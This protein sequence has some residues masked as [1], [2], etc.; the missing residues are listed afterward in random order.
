MFPSHV[1]EVARVRA[2]VRALL[3]GHPTVDDAELVASELATNALRHSRS[4]A[5][6]ALFVVRVRDHGDRVRISVADYGNDEKWDGTPD[7]PDP[8]AEHGRGLLLVASLS[9]DWGVTE[10]PIGTCVWADLASFNKL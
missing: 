6:N 5:P 7:S 1:D 10:E 9:K 2:F 4:A 3:D 8:M